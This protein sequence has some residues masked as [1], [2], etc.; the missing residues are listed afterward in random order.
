MQLSVLYFSVLR[1][2]AGT[3]RE[4]LPMTRETL[5]VGSVIDIVLGKHPPLAEWNEKLLIAVNGEYADRDTRVKPGDEV[6]LMPPVQ[7]G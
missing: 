1:D 4:D 3:D 6:A 5:D 2:V 7:G